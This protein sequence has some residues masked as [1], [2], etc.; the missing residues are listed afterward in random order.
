M[1]PLISEPHEWPQ[2]SNRRCLDSLVYVDMVEICTP[3]AER[4]AHSQEVSLQFLIVNSPV[5]ANWSLTRG[6]AEIPKLS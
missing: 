4:V 6:R 5:E 2:D 3:M 1:R